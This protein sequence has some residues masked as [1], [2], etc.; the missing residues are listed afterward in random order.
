MPV[1]FRTFLI[2]PVGAAHSTGGV[3]VTFLLHHCDPDATVSQC[4][5]VPGLLRYVG[6]CA[7]NSCAPPR[8]Y[9]YSKA[10]AA[11]FP[12]PDGSGTVY[13]TRA[14]KVAYDPGE[15]WLASK[16]SSVTLRSGSCNSKHTL[17]KISPAGSVSALGSP[18][19]SDFKPPKGFTSVGARL[20]FKFG[21]NAAWDRRTGN[22]YL[23]LGCEP[24]TGPSSGLCGKTGFIGLLRL[25]SDGVSLSR[26]AGAWHMTMTLSTAAA[27][28]CGIIAQPL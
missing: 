7:D 21:A 9:Y 11:V 19:A 20:A 17:Q 22:T 26:V 6:A 13:F 3:N 14:C 15:L 4:A 24:H 5:R 25:A 28:L 10:P 18:W 27:F 1:P 12:D 8:A 16:L 23:M 2:G